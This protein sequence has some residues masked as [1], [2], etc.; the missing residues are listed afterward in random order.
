MVQLQP[1]RLGSTMQHSQVSSLRTP[2]CSMQS[3]SP[4][5]LPDAPS[6]PAS[7][8]SPPQ[9]IRPA[10][11][12]SR[13]RHQSSSLRRAHQQSD[14]HGSWSSRTRI[15]HLGPDATSWPD[16]DG[17]A[18]RHMIWPVDGP[19]HGAWRSPLAAWV[20][21]SFPSQGGHRDLRPPRLPS[22]SLEY[23]DLAA[24]EPEQVQG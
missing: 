1:P 9:T 20:S 7:F 8:S 4:A 2:P 6:N 24:A 19:G 3:A 23:R 13:S 22:R 12:S 18:Q 17:S 16:D 11:H 21:P 14:N 10:D 15:L 5:R